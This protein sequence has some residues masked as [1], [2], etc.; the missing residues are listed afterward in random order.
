MLAVFVC[1]ALVLLILGA[2]THLVY[3]RLSHDAYLKYWSLASYASFVQVTCFAIAYG[4][5]ETAGRG[6]LQSLV[7][8]GSVAGYLHP[9]YLLVAALAMSRKPSRKVTLAVTGAGALIAIVFLA[10]LSRHTV[11][12]LTIFRYMLMGRMFLSVGALSLFGVAYYRHSTS[13]FSSS[14]RYTIP[15]LC[16]LQAIHQLLVGI[17][18]A[19]DGGVYFSAGS[20]AGA[21]IAVFLGLS[22]VIAL[23]FGLTEEAQRANTAKSLFLSAMSHEMRTPLAG[24]IGLSSLLANSATE[25]EQKKLADSIGLCANSVLSLV[26]EILDLTKIDAG[27]TVAKRSPVSIQ[28][29]MDELLAM[30]QLAA[31]AKGLELKVVHKSPVPAAVMTD[32]ALLRQI[33]LNLVGNALKF[34]TQGSITI[35]LDYQREA[36]RIS[37]TDTG[38]GIPAADVPHLAEPFFQASNTNDNGARGTG[39]GLHLSQELVKLLGGAE[40]EILSG[41]GEGSTFSFLIPAPRTETVQLAVPEP[42]PAATAALRIL[43]AEDNKVNQMV[44]M[45]MLERLGHQP[46]LAADGREAIACWR[47]SALDLIL[48]DFRMPGMDGA[49]ATQLIRQYEAGQRHIPIIAVTANAF[50]EDR[51]RCLAVGMDDYLTKPV[52]LEALARSIAKWQPKASVP[53]RG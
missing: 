20:A 52:T 3:R 27:R 46:V 23:L 30:F 45:K 41:L 9:A 28:K 21:M 44:L 17:N 4:S 50:T 5:S 36:L 14:L 51:E 43:V 48:M 19:T 35:S 2:T 6:V 40:L 31:E 32:P 16:G 12:L 13:A 37:V 34:T 53:S 1:L 49:E 11:S 39:L 7:G 29:M 47:R 38:Q 15:V 25:G 10:S 22:L 26:D 42:A 24:L 33:L 8:I 18:H